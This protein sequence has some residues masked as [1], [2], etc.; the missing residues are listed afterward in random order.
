ME[1]L[2]VILFLMIN[3]PASASPGALYFARWIAEFA[4]VLVPA[5]LVIGW[6]IGTSNTRAAM[7]SAAFTGLL[8]LAI[9]QVIGHVFP[10]PRPFMIGMGH[11]YLSH[12]ADSSFPSEHLTLLWAVAARLLFYPSTRP[13]GAMLAILGIPLAWSRIYLGVHFPLDMAGA[14]LVAGVAAVLSATAVRLIL[15]RF[16]HPHGQSADKGV[17]AMATRSYPIASPPRAS[18]KVPAV[19]LLFWV[20]KMMSTTV[21]ET[22]ADFLNVDLQLG[23]S[24][25]T[26][27]MGGLL[28]LVLLFQVRARYYAPFPYWLAIVLVSV[29]GTLI[30]DNVT[31]HLGV[32]LIDSTGAFGLALA[33]VFAVWNAREHTLSIHH[34]NSVPRELFYWLAVLITFAL[35][36][37]AGDWVAESLQLGYGLSALLFGGFIAGIAAMRY[38][39]NANAVLCFWLA[40][41]L[42]RPFGAALGD[43]LAQ[44]P[45]DGGL[46]LGATA[47]SALFLATICGLVAYLT[48]SE[49]RPFAQDYR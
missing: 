11:T 36:T 13:I 22:A 45:H 18:N 25:T 48:V 35:G 8:A 40:Y 19:T 1:N 43:L 44:S 27:V 29:V 5:T 17:T 4:I 32:P 42:T 3:A 37:A 30:T 24:G 14:A 6:I 31:D 41:I 33:V 7:W 23:L 46:G 12:A 26:L 10:H 9:A 2:N 21:G 15:R 38:V 49:R 47:T 16:P 39:L 20:I 28:V 34:V